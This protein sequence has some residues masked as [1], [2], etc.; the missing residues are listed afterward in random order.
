[1]APVCFPSALELGLRVNKVGLS[2]VTYEIGVFVKG[3]DAVM[4]VGSFVHVFVDR[5]RRK[6]NEAGMETVMR[7][8]LT[9]ILVD[10]KSRL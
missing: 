3:G 1:M 8:G 7:E 5:E 2:S 4:A 6:P 9:A 10:E